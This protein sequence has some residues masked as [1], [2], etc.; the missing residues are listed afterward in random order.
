MPFHAFCSFDKIGIGL[1]PL[2]T[3]TLAKLLLRSRAQHTG[4]LSRSPPHAVRCQPRRPPAGTRGPSP[5]ALRRRSS[6]QQG[7]PPVGGPGGTVP[8]RVPSSAAYALLAPTAVPSPAH[9]Q[10]LLSLGLEPPQPLHCLSHTQCTLP[11]TC[12]RVPGNA[13]SAREQLPAPLG[14][15]GSGNGGWGAMG[16]GFS[17]CCGQRGCC[18]LHAGKG[19]TAR[20]APRV[21][22]MPPLRLR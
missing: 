10:R 3:V 9:A 18:C 4:A 13:R 21:A 6:C 8:L 11:S 17:A 22:P 7:R 16:P 5:E 15:G 1:F 2:Q 14:G 12:H 19:Q 20:L